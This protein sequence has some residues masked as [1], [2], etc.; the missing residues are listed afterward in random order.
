MNINHHPDPAWLV[1][2]SANALPDPFTVVLRAHLAVCGQCQD[3]LRAAD[4]IGATFMFGASDTQS[5]TPP[6]PFMNALPSIAGGESPV[7]WLQNEPAEVSRFFDQYIGGHLDSLNW[8]RAG[9]GLRVCRLSDDKVNRMWMLRADPGTVLPQHSHTGSE[10]TLILKGAFHSQNNVYRVGDIEDA[11][12]S[13]RHQP[14]VTGDNECVCIAAVDGP[15]RFSSL[16][17]RLVQPL[18]G[19]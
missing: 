12:D 17:P 19:L 2:Y 7:E 6:A 16:L 13:I 11:D 15:L 14:E 10:L 8:M 18:I 4:A 1:S 3:Q 5:E 9:K